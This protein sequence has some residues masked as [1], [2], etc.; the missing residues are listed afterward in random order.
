MIKQRNIF[1]HRR[2]RWTLLSIFLV[3][4]AGFYSKFYKGPVEF[5][6][7]NSLGGVL[8]VIF[9]CLT[10][11]LFYGKGKP[12]IIAVVV[13]TVTCILEFLQ[14]WHPPFLEF[15]RDYFLGKTVLGTSFTWYDFPYYFLGSIIGWFWI[16]R[17]QLL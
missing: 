14:L 17:L 4:P 1:D 8:Y 16:K 5:W 15:I 2:V 10:I 3:V 12:W 11:F 7:N 6:V 9:W 13:L